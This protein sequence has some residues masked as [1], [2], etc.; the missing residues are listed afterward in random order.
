MRALR[1]VSP[2]ISL[3][4]F[5]TKTKKSNSRKPYLH[6]DSVGDLRR[7]IQVLHDKIYLFG[8][9][10][11]EIPKHRDPNKIAKPHIDTRISLASLANSGELPFVFLGLEHLAW[12]F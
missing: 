10:A 8:N 6:L 2:R 4:S 11:T 1:I 5:K 3:S 9:V 7:V 12:W